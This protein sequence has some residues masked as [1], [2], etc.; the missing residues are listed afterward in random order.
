M[1]T[2]ELKR[3]LIDP[4]S[5][6]DQE[7]DFKRLGLT[8]MLEAREIE[9]RDRLEQ[10]RRKRYVD[11]TVATELRARGW[12]QTKE[13]LLWCSSCNGPTTWRDKTGSPSHHTCNED[14]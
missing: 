12:T 5:E 11:L 6:D 10:L 1:N 7:V 4:P 9:A 3:E 2:E 14:W 8:P 13:G